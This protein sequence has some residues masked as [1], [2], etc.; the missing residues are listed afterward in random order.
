M[1][2]LIGGGHWAIALTAEIITTTRAGP[3][4]RILTMSFMHYI[5]RLGNT[6]QTYTAATAPMTEMFNLSRQPRSDA[7]IPNVRPSGTGS[8][9]ARHQYRSRERFSDREMRIGTV[10]HPGRRK[11]T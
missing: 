1:Q 11:N 8:R 9:F 7:S 5:V 3:R 6:P 10:V 4:D 2:S